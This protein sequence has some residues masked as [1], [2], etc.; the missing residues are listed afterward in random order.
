MRS[1]IRKLLCKLL[2][3]HPHIF[4]TSQGSKKYQM[5]TVRT[6]CFLCIIFTAFAVKFYHILHHLNAG[7]K[8]KNLDPICK[9]VILIPDYN[10]SLQSWQSIFKTS[11]ESAPLIRCLFGTNC[12]VLRGWLYY[13][14]GLHIPA[15]P[16]AQV[17]LISVNS[18]Q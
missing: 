2:V 6:I 8:Q 1:S 16:L 3:N 14:T 13:G 11:V 7:N 12:W 5:Q 15:N 10:I 18:L 9:L 17:N 4:L